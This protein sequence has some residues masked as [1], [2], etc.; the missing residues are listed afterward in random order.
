MLRN[1]ESSRV[2]N[3]SRIQQE[4]RD[5]EDYALYPLF[6][7]KALNR[8]IMIKQAV[9]PAEAYNFRKNGARATKLLFPLDRGDYSLGGL[10]LFVG[11]N[12][13]S[14]ELAR[15]FSG[16]Q[17]LSERDENV[18]VMLDQLPTLDPFLM[19]ALLRSN[20]VHVSEIYFQIT[21]NDRRAIQSEMVSEFAPLV[22]LCFPN[23]RQE[24]EKVRVFIDKILNFTEGEELSALRES[25]KLGR[26]EFSMA[27]FA[28]RALIYYKWRSRLLK[29]R[30]E[31]LT[32]GLTR[33]RPTEGNPMGA[34]ML[35]LSRSK[36]LRMA[37]SSGDKVARMI[38]RYDAVFAEFVTGAQV[39]KFRAFLKMAPAMF[40]SCGQSIAILEHI[41]NFFD[42][43][44]K[45]L[46]QAQLSSYD[47]A[48]VL[49]D[50]EVELGLDFQ[51][52]LRIW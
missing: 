6:E 3:L 33:I 38:A 41:I 19:Y 29:S 20:D 27:M 34:R 14:A 43:K 2:L 23:N 28:W 46:R 37:T 50:L 47:F 32:A 45:V 24:S 16:E 17:R 48:R 44:S 26:Y 31:E 40:L 1:A 30:L 49:A 13:F 25:F 5:F 15:H 11:Q 22:N 39:D 9:S 10:Y 51:V 18:L 35:E 36:I 7:N 52:K 21:E 12:N 42:R 4:Y 8:S